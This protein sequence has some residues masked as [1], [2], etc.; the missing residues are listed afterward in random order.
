M[1][2]VESDVEWLSESDT[3]RFRLRV[4]FRSRVRVRVRV[5]VRRLTVVGRVV[6]LV[7][8]GVRSW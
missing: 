7:G 6:R 5:R 8:V 3:A 4:R 1:E 2:P